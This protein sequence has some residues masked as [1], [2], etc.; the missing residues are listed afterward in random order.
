MNFSR[1]CSKLVAE[2]GNSAD[3]W[4]WDYASLLFCSV[5][6]HISHLSPT[7]FLKQYF[8]LLHKKVR[9]LPNTSNTK[10]AWLL[11][12][13]DVWSWTVLWVGYFQSVLRKKQLE[14]KA[15]P[16]TILTPS[17]LQDICIEKHWHA[18][19]NESR[20]SISVGR[21]LLLKWK[22]LCED[23]TISCLAVVKGLIF[24]HT[25][26]VLTHEPC[27]LLTTGSRYTEIISGLSA[28]LKSH[29]T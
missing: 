25:P 1:L 8:S 15:F 27:L 12:S 5:L 16:T 2:Q 7:A 22:E 24:L 4:V 18:N 6:I 29:S 28:F 20:R 14:W 3:S 11:R 23:R 13:S 21:T 26:K 10:A 9:W 17:L 19:P